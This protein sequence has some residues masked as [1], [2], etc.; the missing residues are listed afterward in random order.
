M[1]MGW[2]GDV[3]TDPFYPHPPPSKGHSMCI[4]AHLSLSWGAIIILQR[5]C[6]K[7]LT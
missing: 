4:H 1:T 7:T 6:L 3:Q 2:K 5:S